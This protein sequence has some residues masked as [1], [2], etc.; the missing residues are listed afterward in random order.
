[1]RKF[2][3]VLEEA[4]DLIERTHL[5]RRQLEVLYVWSKLGINKLKTEENKI[6]LFDRTVSVGSFYRVL[7]QARENVSKAI[8]TIF[9]LNACGLIADDELRELID[10]FVSIPPDERLLALRELVSPL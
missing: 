9:L 5:T 2:S 6:R 3:D 10:R 7:R 4:S 1:M 8:N